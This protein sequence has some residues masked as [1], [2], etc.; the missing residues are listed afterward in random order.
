MN[1]QVLELL[2]DF[3]RFYCSQNFYRHWLKCL[4]YT[5]GVKFLADAANCYWLVDAI[6]SYQLKCQRDPLLCE[7]QVWY[8]LRPHQ[9]VMPQ[10]LVPDSGAVLACWKHEPL[11]RGWVDPVIQQVIDFCDFPLESFKLYCAGGVLMLPSEN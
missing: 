11:V 8:L 9:Q 10:I 6:A 5:D 2:T 7:F 3:R 4:L 1:M